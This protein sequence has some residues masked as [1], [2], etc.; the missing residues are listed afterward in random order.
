VKWKNVALLF[1]GLSIGLLMGYLILRGTGRS[2]D[3]EL[4]SRNAA[5]ARGLP[6][7]DF[8]LETL[9]GETVQLSQFRGQPVVINFWG[10][11]CPP[12]RNEMPLLQSAYESY[13]PE[14]VILAV[15]VNDSVGAVERFVDEMGLTFPIL[16]D[17][18][19]SVRMQFQVRGYPTTYFVDGDGVLREQIIGE[20]NQ[21]Q[22]DASLARIGV[23]P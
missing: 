7:T 22:I 14:L 12:C 18:K 3:S 17:E 19:D 11:W 9:T 15:N 23:S 21:E 10:T 16:M 5:P 20:L 6:I 4:T 2:P 8:E 1:G 13:A